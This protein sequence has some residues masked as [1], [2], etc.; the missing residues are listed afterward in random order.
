M[1]LLKSGAM[2]WDLELT[3]QQIDAFELYYQQ[4]V[5]WNRRLS[6][7]TITEY[8]EVQ[9]KHFLDSLSCLQVLTSVP[10]RARCIDVGAGAGFPGLPLKIVRPETKLT[11]LEATRK[12][13]RFLEHVVS[14]LGLGDVE[15]V[16]A[17]AEELGH[18]SGH[19]EGYDVGL[20]RAVARLPVL[21]EYVLPLLLM[22]GIF[23]AQKGVE[24]ADELESAAP[25]MNVLGGRIKEVKTV[26][27]PQL[28]G[29]R[30]LIVVEKVAT[31]PQKY[32]RRPGI[33]AKRPLSAPP[34]VESEN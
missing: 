19:R 26:Q 33:P 13:V 21:L 27:L 8:E 9:V 32:P 5:T 12:K 18:H 11:L 4:L 3:P 22:G 6:L 23:V 17:R 31:T 15:I 7:T 1:E 34:R 2:E 10:R 20:A 28:E 29:I 14:A 24:V 25:A 16:R 30:H